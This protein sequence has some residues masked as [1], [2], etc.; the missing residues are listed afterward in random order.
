[1]VLL[2]CWLPVSNLV[3]KTGIILAERALYPASIGAA[4]LGA[5]VVAAAER[6]RPPAATALLVL[7]AGVGAAITVRDVPAWRD[8]RAVF[9][10]MT[11]RNPESYRGWWYLAEERQSRGDRAG[12]Y[13]A[14]GES[15]QHFDLETKILHRAA[16]YALANADTARAIG[17]LDRALEVDV[18]GRRARTLRVMIAMRQGDLDVARRLL[19]AGLAFEPDQRTWQQW[20]A[21]I[22]A[23]TTDSSSRR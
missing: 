7:L 19:D 18:W 2:L 13:D 5:A 4:L 20:R 14:L 17:W 16:Q 21:A 1:G 10:A 12:A 23:A 15:L 8:S 3:F 11:T 6:W 22:A 9:E